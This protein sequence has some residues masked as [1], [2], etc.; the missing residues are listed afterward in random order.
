MEGVEEGL[1]AFSACGLESLALQW[2][3]ETGMRRGEERWLG[4]TTQRQTLLYISEATGN[5]TLEEGIL[6]F[7]SITQVGK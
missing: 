2:A 7:I 3:W 6:H 1:S 4:W 5:M